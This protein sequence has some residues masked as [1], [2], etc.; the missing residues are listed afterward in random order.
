MA[1]V[2]AVATQLLVMVAAASIDLLFVDGRKAGVCSASSTAIHGM[3][4][5]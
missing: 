5:L 3:L 2:A 4:I 1:V